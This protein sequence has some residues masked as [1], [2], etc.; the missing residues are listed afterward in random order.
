MAN[1]LRG[2]PRRPDIDRAI[3][4]AAI[5]LIREAGISAASIGAVAQRSGISRPTLY[6]RYKD[7]RALLE[8]CIKDIMDNQLSAPRQFD[9]PKD[10]IVELL[11]NTVNLLTKTPLGDLYRATL[12][13][14]AED[15]E[16]ADL[17]GAFGARIR[18]PCRNP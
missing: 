10:Q 7:K 16:L 4:T 8:A 9:D 15:P 2:R 5:D 18:T 3:I 1:A 17:I 12:P 6:R 11:D 14:L 13:H